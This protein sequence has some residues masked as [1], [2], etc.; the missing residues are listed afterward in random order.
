MFDE[1]AYQ[2]KAFQIGVDGYLVK[3]Q[4]GEDVIQ[5]LQKILDGQKVFDQKIL[6]EDETQG[7]ESDTPW[8]LPIT[9]R[10]KEVFIMTVLGHS[11]KEIAEKL[12]ISVKTVENHRR[13]ISK[14]LGSHKRSDW[15]ELA[16]KYNV[17]EL[18]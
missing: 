7:G 6:D 3:N 8:D 1:E 14:K 12:S 4:K 15:L 10:E 18:Y 9:P 11:Q 5:N 17:L 16:R 2:R 13:N